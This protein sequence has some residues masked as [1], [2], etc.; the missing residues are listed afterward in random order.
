MEIVHLQAFS[1]LAAIKREHLSGVPW[2]LLTA[3]AGPQTRT[4][5]IRSFELGSRHHGAFNQSPVA[6]LL[7][8]LGY[9]I[10]ASLV[11]SLVASH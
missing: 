4:Q 6:S 10:V 9:G 7:M 2:V 5:L 8:R 1:K 3:S 11:A